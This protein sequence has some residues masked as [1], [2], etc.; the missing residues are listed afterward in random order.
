MLNLFTNRL[1]NLSINFFHKYS[2]FYFYI[3]ALQKKYYYILKK[4]NFKIS[5]YNLNISDLKRNQVYI[6][7]N[8]YKYE[9]FS[10]SKIL[11][12]L[13][14]LNNNNDSFFNTC[15]SFC[16]VLYNFHYYSISIKYFYKKLYIF[17][18]KNKMLLYKNIILLLL[19]LKRNT[20]MHCLKYFCINR[21]IYTL[22]FFKR[23]KFLN[24][25]NQTIS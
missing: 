24:D 14:E 21:N 2:F 9:I 25:Y 3:F 8:Y 13:N 10:L 18:N 20:F 11:F 4:E 5:Y 16:S 1:Y 12:Q 17:I 22:F 23:Y 7:Y 6:F 15:L 19:V